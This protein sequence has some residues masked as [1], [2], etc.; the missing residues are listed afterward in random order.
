M[1][2]YINKKWQGRSI[3]YELYVFTFHLMISRHWQQKRFVGVKR[4]H[5]LFPRYFSDAFVSLMCSL[6]LLTAMMVIAS[7]RY[8]TNDS[9]YTSVCSGRKSSSETSSTSFHQHCSNVLN[10]SATEKPFKANGHS[11]WNNRCVYDIK[12]LKFSQMQMIN[13]YMMLFF[14]LRY[15]YY[16]INWFGCQDGWKYKDLHIA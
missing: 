7:E 5:Y 12:T 14:T 11:H 3:F 8:K 4:R 2:C 6:L 16:V 1:S 15:T 10:S 13:N 9:T